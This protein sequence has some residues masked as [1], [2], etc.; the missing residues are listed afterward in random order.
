MTVVVFD[1]RPHHRHRLLILNRRLRRRNIPAV[2][3]RQ[4]VVHDLDYAAGH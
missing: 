3:R 4:S 1:N 2:H